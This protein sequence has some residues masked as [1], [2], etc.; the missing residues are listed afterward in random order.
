MTEGSFRHG[1]TVVTPLLR[2]D[3]QEL[4][5]GKRDSKAAFAV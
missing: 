1:F 4:S 2:G 5:S 3:R